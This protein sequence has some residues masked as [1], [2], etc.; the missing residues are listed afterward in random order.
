LKEGLILA[1]LK[2]DDTMEV[3]SPKLAFPFAE[4]KSNES[5]EEYEQSVN[6][7]NNPS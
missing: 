3:N 2:K 4:P 1:E 5:I 7:G 6:T